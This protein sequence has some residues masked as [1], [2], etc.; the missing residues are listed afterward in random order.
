MIARMRKKTRSREE[1]ANKEG[2]V[3]I[4]LGPH[5]ETLR[6][7]AAKREL[8]R[9]ELGRLLIVDGL[10]DLIAGR[11]TYRKPGLEASN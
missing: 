2:K 7:E 11:I 9:T 4:A 3:N 10:R 6:E 1:K 5:L 8:T